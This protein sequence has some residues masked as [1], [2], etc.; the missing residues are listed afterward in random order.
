MRLTCFNK[1]IGLGAVGLNGFN[2][3][4]FFNAF[5]IPVN[6]YLTRIV[7]GVNMKIKAAFSRFK[8]LYLRRFFG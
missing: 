4:I 8:A 5:I 3:L 1:N 7:N 6:P 2:S